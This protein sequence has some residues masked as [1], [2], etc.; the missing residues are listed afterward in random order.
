LIE[1]SVVVPCFNEEASLPALRRRLEALVPFA[2]GR[3]EAV[4][5]DDASRDGT[6]A[7]LRAWASVDSRLRALRLCA[8][9]GTQAALLTGA[10]AARGAAV[11]FLDADLQDPP[12]LLEPMR[13]RL[14]AE[15]LDAVVGLKTRRRD[16]SALESLLKS[17][18][19]SVLPLKTG[20]SDFCVLSVAAARRLLQTGGA[21]QP[22]RVRRRRAL[23]GRSVAYQPYERAAR[24]EGSSRYGLLR[25]ARLWWSFARGFY[26]PGSQARA[27]FLAPPH[28]TAPGAP[29]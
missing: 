21:A 19:V 11:A 17:A 2:A 4:L 28:E 5:V 7:L 10:G 9:S 16:G 23:S 8:N 3:W 18:A 25:N 29:L 1:L 20:E 24:E 13:A 14:A 22:V 26:W 27:P 6:W 15:N 12:E